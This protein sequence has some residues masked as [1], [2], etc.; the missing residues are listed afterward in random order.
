LGILLLCGSIAT[1]L[2]AANAGGVKT[3]WDSPQSITCF[4]VGSATLVSFLCYESRFAGLPII[5]IHLLK[6]RNVA[7]VYLQQFFFG[8]GYFMV[9]FVVPLYIQLVHGRSAFTSVSL[10]L[11]VSQ[12]LN[13]AQQGLIFLAW[14]C[15]ICPGVAVSVLVLRN[16]GRYTEF[17]T[18][19]N[20]LLTVSLGLLSTLRAD[21][22]LGVV[23]GY[24]A[25]GGFAIGY[26]M[27]TSIFAVQASVSKADMAVVTGIRLFVRYL[28]ASVGIVAGSVLVYASL[29]VNGGRADLTQRIHHMLATG[30]PRS[31]VLEV[32]HAPFRLK[33]GTLSPSDRDMLVAGFLR[34]FQTAFQVSAALMAFTTAAA[35][36]LIRHIDLRL[37][38]GRAREDAAEN[39]LPTRATSAPCCW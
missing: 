13:V 23:V 31:L 25:L 29:Y 39:S 37:A 24:L 10:H 34:G 1:I 27:E 9:L 14:I 7:G 11:S 4:A 32:I 15:P 5:P 35:F 26:G 38:H 20:A 3:P 18:F 19:S 30:L 28:G 12:Q 2:Y 36:F 21:T 8:S 17:I 22:G 6:L 33:S 16:T